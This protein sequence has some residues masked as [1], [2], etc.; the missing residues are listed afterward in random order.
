M[1]KRIKERLLIAVSIIELKEVSLGKLPLI[2]LVI[3]KSGEENMASQGILGTTI[4]VSRV[5]KIKYS[6]QQTDEWFKTL[7]YYMEKTV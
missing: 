5:C 2:I 7:Q 4:T 3:E 1:E 6:I